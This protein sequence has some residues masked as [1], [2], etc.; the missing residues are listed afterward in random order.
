MVKICPLTDTTYKPSAT[1][2]VEK[3]IHLK[4]PHKK[5]HEIPPKNYANI[6]GFIFAAKNIKILAEI[7]AIAKISTKV[8]TNFCA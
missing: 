2:I 7:L 1:N 4:F 6:Y 3:Y 8:S 5:P